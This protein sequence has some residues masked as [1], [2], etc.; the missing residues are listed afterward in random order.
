MVE[1]YLDMVDSLS[2]SYNLKWYREKRDNFERTLWVLLI[3]SIFL[4]PSIIFFEF[5][6]IVISIIITILG[7]LFCYWM[8]FLDD[9]YVAANIF[10][11]EL[12]VDKIN[13]MKGDEKLNSIFLSLLNKNNIKFKE[14][15]QDHLEFEYKLIEKEIFIDV[16]TDYYGTSYSRAWYYK[17]TITPLNQDTEIYV[18][19]LQKIISDR[20]RKEIKRG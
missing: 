6:C 16:S 10:F 17:I 18:D 5:I 20:M 15:H 9:K 2:G 3:C 7:I 12:N 13:Q 11:S 19:Y 1:F 14:V 8:I 4:I